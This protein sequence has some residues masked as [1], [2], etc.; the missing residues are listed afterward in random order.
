MC[1]KSLRAPLLKFS[2]RFEVL[3]TNSPLT[4]SAKTSF[5]LR[6]KSLNTGQLHST[7]C[8]LY[9]KAARVMTLCDIVLKISIKMGGC[10]ANR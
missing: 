9:H 10:I 8:G 2:F 6:W 7:S 4:H 1:I 5:F 3:T